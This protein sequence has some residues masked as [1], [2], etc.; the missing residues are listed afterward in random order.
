[1]ER[2]RS[3]FSDLVPIM[4]VQNEV[5]PKKLRHVCFKNYRKA[6]KMYKKSETQTEIELV[7]MTK[8][9]QILS[10]ITFKDVR[11]LKKEIT[12]LILTCLYM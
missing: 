2:P 8:A 9:R 1:M 5:H 11:K 10:Q 3:T 4:H 12:Q 6:G 7:Q